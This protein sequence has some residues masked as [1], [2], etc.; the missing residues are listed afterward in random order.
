M[1]VVPRCACW[2]VELLY[3]RSMVSSIKLISTC[4]SHLNTGSMAKLFGQVVVQTN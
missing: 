1:I 2:W 3:N 4:G